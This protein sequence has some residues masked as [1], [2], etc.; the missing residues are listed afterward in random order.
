MDGFSLVVL[1]K[2]GVRILEF[3]EGFL[4]RQAIDGGAGGYSLFGWIL[5]WCFRHIRV[6]VTGEVEVVLWIVEGWV[7]TGGGR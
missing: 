2:G 5:L 4:L 6:F 3:R 7:K 1:L